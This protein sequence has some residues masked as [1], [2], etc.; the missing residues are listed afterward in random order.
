MRMG[1]RYGDAMGG[2]AHKSPRVHQVE[3]FIDSPFGEKGLEALCWRIA[4][5]SRQIFDITGC[6]GLVCIDIPGSLLS[7]DPE[8]C[9]QMPGGK[10][11]FPQ[12]HNLNKP[13]P[14]ERFPFDVS[15]ELFAIAG[16][17]K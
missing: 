12:T 11:P 2:T 3:V 15:Q 6:D 10:V 9:H 5:A 13:K 1:V 14:Q 16:S 8:S 17:H 4:F 7:F